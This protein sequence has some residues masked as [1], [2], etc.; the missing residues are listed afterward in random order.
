MNKEGIKALIDELDTHH[1]LSGENLLSLLENLDEENKQYLHTKANRNRLQHYDDRVYMRGL[2]E[3]TNY[4]K[5]D[6]IYCGIRKS[7][8]EADRYRL[9]KDEILH[10]CDVGYQ[11][12]YRTYVLQ[13]GEDPYYTDDRVVDIVRS[14]KEKYKD[15]AVTLSIGE[16]SYATYKK[17]YDAGADR[18]LLRHETHS[19]TLYERLHPHMSYDNRI[20]CL[21]DLKAIGF[22][23]GAGFM[24]GLPS[25]T[26]GDYVK[27]LLFLK[28]LEPHMVG[29]GPFIPQSDTPLAHEKGGTVEKTCIL[30]SL[31]RLLL[32]EVLLPATTALGS[33]HSKGREMGLKSGANVVMP[34][35]SPTNVREKYALYD[36]KICTG[37][38]AAHCRKCIEN[39]IEKSGYHVDMSRGDHVT[40]AM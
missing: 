30:L 37:D 27:D 26:N 11:L 32:P 17:Y 25:Q 7:N 3:F 6:C 34:N 23:V 35:L 22:Q 28:Q 24:V 31:V 14:I 15:V 5:R 12:G 2:I 29:I 4:C 38:E 39:R 16:K 13:G 33:L 1:I 36:G 18:Y 10:C 9:S 40:R 19:R 8:K 20:R 21:E